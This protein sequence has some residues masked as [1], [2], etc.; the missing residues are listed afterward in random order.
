MRT[1][2]PVRE[3][4]VAVR[5][6]NVWYKV[7]GSEEGVPLVTVHGGPGVPHD[8]L[9]PLEGLADARP[10]VFYDQLGAGRSDRSDDVSL[11][12]NDRF[13]DELE[14]LVDALQLRRLHLFGHSWG[15]IIAAEYA[16]RRQASL[17]SL[18]LASPVL[19]VPRYAAGAVALRA[20]LPGDVRDVLDSHEA[21]GTTESEEYQ[22][23]T[24][25]FYARYI[26]RLDPW[27]DALMRSFTGL[28]PVIYN[29]MQGPNEFV[30]TGIHK[31][32]DST[33]R[34]PEITVPTLFTCGRYDEVRAENVAWQRS[35]LPGS[36]LAIFERSAHM[37]HLEETAEYLAVI[38]DFLHRAESR[39]LTPAEQQERKPSAA[40]GRPISNR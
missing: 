32:Y 27:P 4:L 15:S 14:R 30:I 16:L 38:R 37:P 5:G 8:Y 36:E 40:G 25:Q 35:L 2:N 9:E 33:A 28:N 39:Q 13:V 7:V 20:S 12:R 31:D 22:A 23:A 3:G 19:S 34:L 18:I 10:V 11:W 17:T 21:A 1:T 29:T 26:C 24:M 6:G